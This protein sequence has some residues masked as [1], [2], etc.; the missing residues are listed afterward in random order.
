MRKCVQEASSALKTCDFLDHFREQKEVQ[1]KKVKILLKVVKTIA[2]KLVGIREQQL[3]I[4]STTQKKIG[5]RPIHTHFH[6]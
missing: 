5:V 6:V 3:E 4:M 2:E 1:E